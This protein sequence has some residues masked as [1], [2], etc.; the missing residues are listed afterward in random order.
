MW[1]GTMAALEFHT[2]FSDEKG[3]LKAL[4]FDMDPSEGQT[5]EDVR[6]CAG[7]VHETLEKLGVTSYAKTSGASGIADIYPHKTHDF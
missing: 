1:L 5:F 3:M 6:E 4:V 2:P 7:I